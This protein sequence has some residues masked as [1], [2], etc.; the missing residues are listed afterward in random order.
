MSPGTFPTLP[1]DL[2]IRYVD[3]VPFLLSPQALVGFCSVAINLSKV[4]PD[5]Q[6]DI[7]CRQRAFTGNL[8]FRYWTLKNYQTHNPALFPRV[9]ICILSVV[10]SRVNPSHKIIYHPLC[11]NVLQVSS[12]P[13]LVLFFPHSEHYINNREPLKSASYDS[14]ESDLLVS[15]VGPIVYRRVPVIFGNSSYFKCGQL[16]LKLIFH[17]R[18]YTFMNIIMKSIFVCIYSV[19]LCS[20][21]FQFSLM[22]IIDKIYLKH[23]LQWHK[24]PRSFSFQ[25]AFH[26][27]ASSTRNFHNFLFILIC[28]SPYSRKSIQFCSEF[29]LIHQLAAQSDHTF[30]AKNLFACL[31]IM[32]II[33]FLL[34][35]NG[36]TIHIHYNSDSLQQFGPTEKGI[37]CCQRIRIHFLIID[38]VCLFRCRK[39][40]YPWN[41]CMCIHTFIPTVPITKMQSGDPI[42]G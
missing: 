35:E 15:A 32:L 2:L 3:K 13:D 39:L 24:T 8:F 36:A 1:S 21:S 19:N 42:T 23:C 4:T 7:L 14:V 38:T 30:A 18:K 33:C 16:R 6:H 25:E 40:I 17:K 27:K 34:V 31:P 9:H 37:S 29:Q 12:M 20:S 5:R 41:F 22:F 26:T 28:A 11:R 10:N